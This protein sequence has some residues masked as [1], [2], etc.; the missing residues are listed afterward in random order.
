ME[1][2]LRTAKDNRMLLALCLREVRNNPHP[3]IHTQSTPHPHTY[4]YIL[5]PEAHVPRLFLP[6]TTFN[7]E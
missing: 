4:S 7:L 2:Q 6:L 1:I 5:T 3:H